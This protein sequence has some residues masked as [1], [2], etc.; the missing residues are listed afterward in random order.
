[1]RNSA[2]SNFERWLKMKTN[3]EKHQ[4]SIVKKGV[5]KLINGETT[6]DK[7]IDYMLKNISGYQ[8]PENHNVISDSIDIAIQEAK[9]EVFDD[10]EKNEWDFGFPNEEANRQLHFMIQRVKKRHLSTFPKK[11]KEHN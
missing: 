2:T 6:K 5:R 10:I 11:E 9:K 4:E 3:R 1:M 8:I 7:A